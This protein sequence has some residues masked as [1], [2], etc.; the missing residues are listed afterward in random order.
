MEQITSSK[1]RP[2]LLFEGYCYRKERVLVDDRESWRCAM[3]TC[4]GRIHVNGDNVHLVSQHGHAPDPAQCGS[5]KSQSSL[6]NRAARSNDAAR[7]IIQ[8]TQTETPAESIAVMPKYKS[9][10]RTV[11]RQ[12]RRDG[13]PI[14]A[15]RNVAEIDI[16][17]NLRR[18][19]RGEN[20]LLHDSGSDDEHRFFIFGTA[21]NLHLLKEH[22][23]WFAD[24]TFKMAPQLFYQVY[25]IHV[26]CHGSVVP[27]VYVLLLNKTQEC[28][29]RVLQQIRNI[30]PEIQ[31]ESV[32]CDFEKAF[33]NAV[34]NVFGDAVHITGCLFHLSQCVWR[35]IQQLQLSQ[36]YQGDEQKRTFCKMLLALAFVPADEIVTAFETVIEN[37]PENFEPLVDYFED[38]WIGRPFRRGR[39]NPTFPPDMWSVYSRVQT[40]LPRTNNAVEGWHNAMQSTLGHHHPTFYKLVEVLR[41]EQ[42]HTENRLVRLNAGHR[43]AANSTY[44]R[45]TSALKTVVA[46]FENRNTEEYLRAISYNLKMHN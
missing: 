44:M 15:P 7:R 31:P 20:F 28:Y 3:S 42:S 12:R 34:R 11:Q 14:A 21:E 23:N 26:L 8:E 5:K 40:D 17:N 33:Q 46:D 9:L 43:D 22:K 6:R 29:I 18:S 36:E 2:Q 16:P 13:E 41:L 32:M 25:T 24:G 37:I 27:A 19:I 39:R 45:V 4:K 38:T 1:S 35:K 30:D 10:Q